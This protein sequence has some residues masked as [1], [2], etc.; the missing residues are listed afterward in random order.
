MPARQAHDLRADK[1]MH[2][3]QAAD[4]AAKTLVRL[5][6][7]LSCIIVVSAG[8]QTW[9][10]SRACLADVNGHMHRLPDATIQRSTKV[11]SQNQAGLLRDNECAVA[12]T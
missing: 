9:I 5:F 3:Q 12:L 11:A 1:M 10:L 8:V 2:E 6:D 7:S 4:E